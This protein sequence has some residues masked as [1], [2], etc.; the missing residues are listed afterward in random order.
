MK[1][2]KSLVPFS[3][4]HHYGLLCCWKIRQGIKKGI[5]AAR[6]GLYVDYFW[7]TYL[8][9]HFDEEE[10]WLFQQDDLSLQA[11]AEHRELEALVGTLASAA[12]NDRLTIF[13]DLLDRHI[14]FEERVLFPHLEATVPEE[15]L[16][17]IGA[18]LHESHIVP[19]TEDYTD[20]FWLE[21]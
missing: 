2:H 21:T 9:Q 3:R 19:A 11:I 18:L 5:A 6:I 12:A 14:R 10:R 20:A 13:A 16:E 17:T 7:K 8:K 4:D 1:R 15:K